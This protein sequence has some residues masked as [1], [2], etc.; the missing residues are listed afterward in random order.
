MMLIIDKDLIRRNKLSNL[1]LQERILQIDPSKEG[2]DIPRMVVEKIFQYRQDISLI[3]ASLPL[4]NIIFSSDSSVI[5]AK[6]GKVQ[7]ALPYFLT[8]YTEEEENHSQFQ[9][10][11]DG[12]KKYNNCLFIKYDEK[13][14]DFSNKYIAKIREVYPTLRVDV[15]KA[16]RIWTGQEIILTDEHVKG[17]ADIVEKEKTPEEVQDI[18][19]L[20]SPEANATES[21]EKKIDYQA[22]FFH[23]LN[24]NQRLKKELRYY[25]EKEIRETNKIFDFDVRNFVKKEEYDAAVETCRKLTEEN[26]KLKEL[27]EVDAMLKKD[28]K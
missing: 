26:K 27:L 22:L 17:I 11:M 16:F 15:D 25:Q 19:S 18:S 12:L 13:D 10:V 3:M 4:A 8:Y 24:E 20:L 23:T 2:K 5:K 14:R 21:A 7:L 9:K 1:L 28:K 6:E